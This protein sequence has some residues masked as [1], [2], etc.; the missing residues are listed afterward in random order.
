MMQCQLSGREISNSKDGSGSTPETHNL[1]EPSQKSC[2]DR[3]LPRPFRNRSAVT[4]RPPNSAA[5]A[6]NSLS[7]V[8]RFVTRELILGG[9]FRKHVS[10]PEK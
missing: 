8:T 3:P 7:P 10:I 9:E 6:N 5:I 4:I 1:S 2:D